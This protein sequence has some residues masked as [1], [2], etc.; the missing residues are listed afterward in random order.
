MKVLL[1]GWEFPPRISGGLGVAC[2]AIVKEL[3]RK[4]VDVTV[5]LPYAIE[6]DITNN[7]V[8]LKNCENST[9]DDECDLLK[10]I[11]IKNVKVPTCL[12][13][14]RNTSQTVPIVDSAMMNELFAALAKMHLPEDLQRLAFESADY[15]NC[16]QQLTGRYGCNLL[17]E[18]FRYA[19]VAGAYA[20]SVPHDI[21][22]AHDWLTVLAGVEA[23]RISHKP[24]VFHVH[25]LEPDRSGMFVDQRI[26]AIEKYGLEQADK[27][28]A[29]SQYTKN[30]IVQHYGI[31]PDKIA[32]VHN[33]TY[34]DENMVY[35]KDKERQLS[36]PEMVLFVGRLTHQ[37]GPY[38]FIEIAHKVLE[39]RSDVQFVIAGSGD[40]FVDMIE[41]V[42]GMRIGKNVHF[43]GFLDQ[44]AVKQLYQLADVYVMPSVSEPFG[45]S[46]LE[47]LSNNV[48]ALISK[49]SGVSEVC[50]HVLISDF[51]DVDDM[52]AKILAL[53]EYRALRNTTLEHTFKDLQYLTWEKTA[54]EIIKVYNS[55][56]RTS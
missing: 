55:Q 14:Y 15:V 32:V 27:I 42:A 56:V 10:R 6:S 24:L 23:K 37:K 21:I 51:W 44:N 33:G 22:H 29:V 1:Y 43:T 49:Q 7:R 48:P 34:L 47:A 8:A 36:R 46:C 5:V 17:A 39:K 11:N 35:N 25:A 28:I 26:F 16:G 19:A 18:V 3:A 20:A 31:N 4:D 54:G 52:S 13:L 53:L 41:K 30:T 38:Y 50:K 45:L 12:N 9:F 2:Y 40:L